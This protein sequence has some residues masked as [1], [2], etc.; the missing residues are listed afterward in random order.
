MEV[1]SA[2]CGLDEEG[3]GVFLFR[4]KESSLCHTVPNAAFLFGI[5][6]LSLGIQQL[7]CESD[8]SPPC[9]AKVM[10]LWSCTSTVP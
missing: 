8:L 2:Y 3:T 6:F 1:K 10:D 9:S 5:G 4:A 7:E